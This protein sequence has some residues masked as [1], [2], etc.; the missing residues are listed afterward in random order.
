MSFDSAS[1]DDNKL[2]D[3]TDLQNSG[4]DSTA[5]NTILVAQ[6]A[7][8]TEMV[9]SNTNLNAGSGTNAGSRTSNIPSGSSTSGEEN[10]AGENGAQGDIQ[11]GQE[12]PRRLLPDLNLEPDQQDE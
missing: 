2:A 7:M 4:A 1:A 10:V 3:S 12:S 8:E 11:I 6:K 9:E 5:D